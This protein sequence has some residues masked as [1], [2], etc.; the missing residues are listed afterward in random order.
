MGGWMDEGRM[1]LGRMD[2]GMVVWR[3]DSVLLILMVLTGS[4]YD[5]A[6]LVSRH[7]ISRWTEGGCIDGRM[8]GW[9]DG[10]REDGFR[11]D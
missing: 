3:E 8:D 5:V 7:L 10:R 4:L 9:M 6:T 1:D 11:E 2:R